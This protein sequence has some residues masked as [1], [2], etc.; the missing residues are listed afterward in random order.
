MIWFCSQGTCP[1]KSSWQVFLQ[2]MTSATG[3]PDPCELMRTCYL[4]TA[5]CSCKTDT[6]KSAGNDLRWCGTS[7]D[8]KG[9]T[10]YKVVSSHLPPTDSTQ[11]NLQVSSSKMSLRGSC[12]QRCKLSTQ[13]S[14][15]PLHLAPVVR[16][17][18]SAAAFQ[19]SSGPG[20]SQ[21]GDLAPRQTLLSILERFSCKEFDGGCHHCPAQCLVALF[22]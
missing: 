13:K 21:P 9:A 22:L 2:P 19:D 15:G 1:H 8:K 10:T 7:H 11:H 6:G 3:R 20:L 5:A 18:V 12:Q 14:I 16:P 17:T 4:V